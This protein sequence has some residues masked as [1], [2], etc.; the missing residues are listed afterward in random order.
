MPCGFT[1]ERRADRIAMENED[2]LFRATSMTFLET[3]VASAISK[4]CKR[5]LLVTQVVTKSQRVDCNTN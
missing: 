4:N 2:A 5:M 1:H 3:L